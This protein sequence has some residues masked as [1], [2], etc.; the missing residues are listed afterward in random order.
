LPDK[1]LKKK[2]QNKPKNPTTTKPYK[3]FIPL[4]LED[5]TNEIIL[6]KHAADNQLHSACHLKDPLPYWNLLQE[7]LLKIYIFPVDNINSS[8]SLVTSCIQEVDRL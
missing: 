3:F 4:S 2:K 5:G 1:G 8:C 7:P 6:L